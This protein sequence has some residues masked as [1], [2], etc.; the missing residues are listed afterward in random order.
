MLAKHSSIFKQ[1]A[2]LALVGTSV[3]TTPTHTP[4]QP[5]LPHQLWEACVP[6]STGT[7]YN[8]VESGLIKDPVCIFRVPRPWEKG[9]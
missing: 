3:Y 5:M 2:A 1:Q 6:I 4:W 8:A 7:P 9:L